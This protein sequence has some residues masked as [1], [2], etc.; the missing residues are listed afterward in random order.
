MNKKEMSFYK[1]TEAGNEKVTIHDFDTK[2]KHLSIG[3]LTLNELLNG[4]NDLTKHID[5][6]QKQANFWVRNYET[7]EAEMIKFREGDFEKAKL[8][9]EKE[10]EI[11]EHCETK[12]LLGRQVFALTHL[13]DEQNETILQYKK[14]LEAILKLEDNMGNF[15][16]AKDGL[17]FTKSK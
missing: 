4:S 3:D 10:A 13:V 15:L 11:E 6:F 16:R 9:N 2:I 14:T 8:L 5:E 17:K 1:F 12:G 7:M